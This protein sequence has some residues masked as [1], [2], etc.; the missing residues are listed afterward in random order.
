[1]SFGCN[2]N[3]RVTIFWIKYKYKYTV[4]LIVTFFILRWN[5]D[6]SELSRFN[7]TP[8]GW[9][10]VRTFL[11]RH[12]VVLCASRR[13]RDRPG[14]QTEVHRWVRVWHGYGVTICMLT[15][16][17][18]F[19]IWS[20]TNIVTFVHCSIVLKQSFSNFFSGDPVKRFVRDRRPSKF[21]LPRKTHDLFF[22][23]CPVCPRPGSGVMATQ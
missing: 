5:G 1:M 10:E 20:W 6:W 23:F 13:T 17:F 18:R 16:F 8:I 15:G 22:C 7:S 3:T 19:Q 9:R 21:F 12:H 14:A 11:L 2:L 4:N